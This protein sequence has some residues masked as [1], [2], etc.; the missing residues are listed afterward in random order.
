MN[1]RLAAAARCALWL[2]SLGVLCACAWLRLDLQQPI[3]T[4]I[5][6]ALPAQQDSGALRIANQRSRDA[7]VN[8]LL[9]L[10]S[11]ADTKATREAAFA[12]WTALL[13]S[14]MHTENTGQSVQRLLAVYQAH[15]FAM[16]DPAQAARLSRGGARALA[17]DVAV[18]LAS[19]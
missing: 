14:G 11:G 17:T 9:V 8:E 16:L 1:T 6:A 2:A 12:A 18:S 5:L 7:F 15:H 4:D 13:H 10:V 3:N 19:P